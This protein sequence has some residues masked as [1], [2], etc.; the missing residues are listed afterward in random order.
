MADDVIKNTEKAKAL[1]L[2]AKS[3]RDYLTCKITLPLGNPA[4]KK[5]HTNQMCWTEIPEDFALEN[6]GVIAN[7]L[8]SQYTRYTGYIL[9]RWYIEGVTIDVDWTG[10][11]EMTLELNAFPS[12]THSWSED[13]TSFAKAYTDAVSQGN[14]TSNTSSTKST[15]NAVTTK[16]VLNNEWIK[17]YSIDK[18]VTAQVEK[19]CKTSYTTYDN[20]KAIF[21]WMNDHIGY[22]GYYNHRYSE[23]Q[24]LKRGKGNCVDNSRLFRAMCQS[25]GVKC[26]YIKNSCIE[27]QYNK[28]YIG[29]KSYIVDVGRSNA[30]WGSHWGGTGCP[31]ETTVSW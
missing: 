6:W 16:S 7:A 17:K 24:V 28:V 14:T 20:V 11:A 19:I 27:H 26:N 5:V 8:Q 9:N 30:T 12:N 23:A 1:E 21:N 3:V 2:I 13:Y 31:S 15:T 22:D 29:S 4:L 18:T 25:I 10:K